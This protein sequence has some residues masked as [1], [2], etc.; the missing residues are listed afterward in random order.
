MKSLPFVVATV[1][2]GRVVGTSVHGKGITA[3]RAAG[4][5]VVSAKSRIEKA[6]GVDQEG[7]TV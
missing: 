3:K 1:E 2:A 6:K 5:L 7:H 4:L